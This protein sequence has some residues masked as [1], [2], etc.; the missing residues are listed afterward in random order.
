MK[1]SYVLLIRVEK[2]RKINIGRLGVLEF[3]PG[4]YAYVGSGMNNLEKRV[5]RHLGS[6][7]KFFWHIDYLLQRAGIVEV[8]QAESRER[9]EC[10]I[11]GRLAKKLSSV[12]RF[13][14]SD[15]RCKSHLFYSPD[16]RMMRNGIID[17]LEAV[18]K[19]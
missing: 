18:Q 17:A 2:A 7:K 14:S 3:R 5:S 10:G 15:C 1:G 11:A 12:P 6:R 9:L 13:G 8:F 16:K 4:F 19:G